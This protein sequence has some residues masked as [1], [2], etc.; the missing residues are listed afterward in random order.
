[1]FLRGAL[2]HDIDFLSA[3]RKWVFIALV[4]EAERIRLDWKYLFYIK[5]KII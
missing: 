5:Y 4:F 1:M 2:P 3:G